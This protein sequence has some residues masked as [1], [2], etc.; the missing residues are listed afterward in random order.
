MAEWTCFGLM[1]ARG[2]HP[3]GQAVQALGLEGPSAPLGWMASCT[4]G[5]L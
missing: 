4:R 5:L 2:H 1:P 3:E